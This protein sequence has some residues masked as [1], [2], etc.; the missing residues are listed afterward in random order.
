VDQGTTAPIERIGPAG[1][2]TA[3]VVLEQMTPRRRRSVAF[4][5]ALAISLAFG[6]ATTGATAGVTDLAS[7]VDGARSEKSDRAIAYVGTI[8]DKRDLSRLAIGTDG[9]WFPYFAA[10]TPASG[11]PTGA[12]VRD[13]LPTWIGAFNHTTSP[14]DFGC[15]EPGAVERGCLPTF[16]FRTFS[17][18][19]PARAA[20][21]F[22]HWAAL[23][24]PGGE[25]GRAGAIVDRKTYS[26]DRPIP[27]PTGLVI[28]PEGPPRPTNNNTMNRIQL[29]D[30]APQTFY[31]GVVTDTTGGDYDA[32]VVEI[33]G[34]VGLIDQRP[35]VADSQIEASSRPSAADLA[36]NG[37]PDIHVFRIDNFRSGDYLKLRLRGIDAPASFSGLLFDVSLPRPSTATTGTPR[38]PASPC[39]P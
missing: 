22:R 12:G 32:G 34:N 4:V 16:N 27:D 38:A 11:Q 35:E 30:G 24:I 18:D 9:S 33:R 3:R 37:V 25:C 2:H 23:R 28:P 6:A 31:V 5:A 8:V 39:K 15:A 14:A 17:Q 26:A 13:R 1:V 36:A 20:G 21:G 19:G 7:T 29:Q 10:T